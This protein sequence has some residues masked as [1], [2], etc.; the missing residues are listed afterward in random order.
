MKKYYLIAERNIGEEVSRIRVVDNN[1]SVIEKQK[2]WTMLLEI[3]ANSFSEAQK[4]VRFQKT[5]MGNVEH[6]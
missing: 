6:L 1:L 5:I 3:E 2:S 4:K